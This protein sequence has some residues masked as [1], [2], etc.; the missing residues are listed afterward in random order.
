MD[1]PRDR[2]LL[3]RALSA[4]LSFRGDASS[5]AGFFLA[6]SACAIYLLLHLFADGPGVEE[7]LR[8]LGENGASLTWFVILSAIVLR[9]LWA[10]GGSRITGDVALSITGRTEAPPGVLLRSVFAD[11][12]HTPLNVAGVSV[13][14]SA[15]AIVLLQAA[16]IPYAG[17]VILFVLLPVL[18]LVTYGAARPILRWLA[19]GHLIGAGIAI[20]GHTAFPAE[21][22]AFGWMNSD[23]L[24]VL[25]L[26]LGAFALAVGAVG[27]R[28]AGLALLGLLI[29]WTAPEALSGGF[30]KVLFAIAVWWT[31]TLLISACYSLRAAQYLILRRALDGTPIDEDSPRTG[32]P[33]L[34]AMGLELVKRLGDEETANEDSANEETGIEDSGIEDSGKEEE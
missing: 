3:D 19:S 2:V 31:A 25:G 28:A 5:T 10:V 4:S 34:T 1:A 23:P 26:R 7:R 24:R 17:K 32:R 29:H 30:G 9:V 11:I 21:T 22:A 14:L 20:D 27:I 15:L 6:I 8:N 13:L 16:R 18:V 33:D 12:Y